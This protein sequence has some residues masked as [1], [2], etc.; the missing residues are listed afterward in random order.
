MMNRMT[1][2]SAG[3]RRIMV[4]SSSVACGF[5]AASLEALQ[6]DFSFHVSGKTPV[7]FAVGA[8][9]VW[10]YWRI[11]F[12]ASKAPRQNRLRFTASALLILAGVAGF[13]YPLRF[14]APNNYADVLIG[15]AIAFGVL[16]GV[17]GLLLYCKRF[18][19]E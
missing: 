14:I 18:L 3:L 6:P 8:A 19:D 15:L 7:A 1:E 10:I 9:L 12:S 5:A 13:L 17:A 11:I 2:F 4:L 16:S